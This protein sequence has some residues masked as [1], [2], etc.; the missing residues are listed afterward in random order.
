[1]V[2]HQIDQVKKIK[3]PLVQLIYSQG[4]ILQPLEELT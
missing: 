3:A 1:M 2:H 4:G